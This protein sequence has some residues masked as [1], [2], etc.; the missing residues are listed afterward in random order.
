MC[1]LSV[2]CIL[3]RFG[4]VNDVLILVWRTCS[5]S[6][7]VSTTSRVRAMD[8][9]L[10]SWVIDGLLLDCLL[11]DSMRYER[12]ILLVALQKLKC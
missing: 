9:T 7:Q 4:F 10:G 3:F 11:L 8:T 1:R 5:I 2:C 6:V 12:S